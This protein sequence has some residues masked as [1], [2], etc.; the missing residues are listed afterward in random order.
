MK[1]DVGDSVLF[2]AKKPSNL[3]ADAPL[4]PSEDTS[5]ALRLKVASI[6][7]AEAFGD[8]SLFAAQMAPFNAFVSLDDLQDRVDAEGKANLLLMGRPGKSR[9]LK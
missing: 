4:A 6:L 3:S 2:R 8:F 9:R 5:A 1:V 7:G